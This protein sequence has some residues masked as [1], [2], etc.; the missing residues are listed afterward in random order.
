MNMTTSTVLPAVELS[1]RYTAESGRVLLSGTQALVRLL[2]AQRR[3]DQQRG[4][5]TG[6]L[7]SGYPGS[8]LGGLDTEIA[9]SSAFLEPLGVVFRPAVNEELAATAIAG[10]QLIDEVTGRRVD[11][12]TG[13]W[14]GKTPGLDRAMDAI[15][16]ATISGTTHLGGAVALIGDD[17]TCK[18]STIPGSCESLCRSLHMP[19]LAPASVHEIVELGLHAVAMSRATGVWTGL[20]I[21]SDIADASSTVELGGE[22]ATIPEPPTDG[23]G[24]APVLLA[25]TSV[26][27]EHDLVTNRW[28]R[29]AEYSTLASLNRLAFDPTDP[30]TAIVA[31]GGAYATLQ[32]A[33]QRLGVGHEELER[34]GVRV[35]QLRL[36][37]PITP[38]DVATLI[39]PVD[40]VIVVEDKVAFVETQLKELLYGRPHAP[41]ILGKRDGSG[42]ELFG[43]RGALSVDDVVAGLSRLLPLDRVTSTGSADEPSQLRSRP[44][45]LGLPVVPSRTPFFCSGCPHNLSTR[46]PSDA[47]VGAGIGCH[48]LVALAPD[49]TRGNI[50]G[51][52]QMGG[53]GAHWIGL[54]P[55]T[56]DQH[57]TQ[58]MGDGTFH[59]SGSLAIRA[60]VAS[61]ANITFKILYNDAVAMTGGQQPEGRLDVPA[62]TRWLGVEGVQKVTVV[63]PEPHRYGKGS[64]PADVS[65]KHRDSMAEAAAELASTS[66]VTALVY[67]DQCA[68]EER[69]LRKR[70]QLPVVTERVWI[71]QRVCEG[72]GDCGEQSSCMS[73]VPVETDFGR[74]TSIHQASCNSDLSCLKGDCPSFVMIEP[75]AVR[76]RRK[77]PDLPVDLVNPTLQT[78]SANWLLRMPGVGGTGVVTVSAIL[79]M[80]AMLDGRHV[81]GLD[82]TGLAQKGGAVVSD[83][84][85]ADAPILSGAR[86]SAGS[87]TVLL[88]LDPI[89]AADSNTL[90]AC[91]PELTIAVVNTGMLPT[92]AMVTDASAGP[93]SAKAIASRVDAAT[94]AESNFYVD[95]HALAQALFGDHMPANLLMLGV[96]F[97][98]GL[99]PLTEASIT[100]AIEL[101]GTSVANN[102]AAFRWGR[103]VA[104]DRDAVMVTVLPQSVEEQINPAATRLVSEVASSG[105]IQSEGLRDLVVRRA[106][107][108]IDFQ[109]RRYAEEFVAAVARVA[110]VETSHLGPGH[111][112]IAETFARGLHKLMAYKDE[113][114][115]ARLHLLDS[116]R[117]RLEL[118]FGVG[119][120]AA[121]MLHPP[122]LRALGM[123]NKVRFGG[124]LRPSLKLLRASRRLRGTSFDPFGRT[125]IRRVERSLPSEYIEAVTTALNGLTKD[126]VAQLCA[127]AALPD[128]VRGYEDIKLG[129][130]RRYRQLVGE[131]VAAIS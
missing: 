107:D 89:G 12:V 18:S 76:R 108:L 82:Q 127:L 71:N 85:L 124:R 101:N 4:L 126:N 67:D 3:L 84:R 8:P 55:F 98:L 5:R 24:P 123:K 27:A 93:T 62:L 36:P 26:T 30:T 1:D 129:N 95:S 15:R 35:V 119:A 81:A 48:A 52:P 47:L 56:D 96:A 128:V 59:H 131:H 68:T 16:H 103:A 7:V 120:K 11:G 33:M 57:F 44:A 13:F 69:R 54:A 78:D 77:L 118:E 80:A 32:R 20:K 70:G 40:R 50:I 53:E 109:G 100:R 79:Q 10:T 102:L 2:I 66:G 110:G 58:N 97:Q 21:T 61:G 51:A 90:A 9:R 117:Q 74:K 39:E 49:S 17:P 43:P 38:H 29:V 72:C 88:G 122:L 111:T 46:A 42:A 73:V 104:I 41:A 65:V 63:T 60:A 14:Y 34:M 83:V 92:A 116:E 6:A 64:L 99:I 112:D 28:E 31:A 125:E 87:I 86:A 19:L 37:Y 25:P 114:E 121:I 106:S 91:S 115:V 22:M 94:R 113:Y 130:V 23:R 105:V 45:L 75:R